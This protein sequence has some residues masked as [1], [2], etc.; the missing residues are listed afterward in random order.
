MSDKDK[1]LSIKTPINAVIHII[2]I[3]IN[4]LKVKYLCFL[5]NNTYCVFF[6][7]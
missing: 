3:S 2:I 6:L 7:I 1:L 5:K 4:S